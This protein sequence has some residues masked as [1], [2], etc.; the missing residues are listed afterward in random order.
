MWYTPVSGIWQTVWLE[1]VPRVFIK[2]I[3]TKL[4]DFDKQIAK[5]CVE[6]SDPA[7]DIAVKITIKDKEFRMKYANKQYT[8]EIDLISQFGKLQPWSPETPSLYDFQ[9][10]TD[11]DTVC[12]YFAIR[13]IDIREISF[14]ENDKQRMICLNGRPYFFNG[15][16]D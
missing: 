7:T 6:L 16:L 9:I 15:L 1:E 10:Q 13:N 11:A 4:V 3:R 14:G 2:T 5:F 8:T 12:S